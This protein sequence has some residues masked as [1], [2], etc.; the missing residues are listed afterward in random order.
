MKTTSLPTAKKYLNFLI[1][2]SK[3]ERGFTSFSKVLARHKIGASVGTVIKE[4]GLIKKQNGY[5]VWMSGTP[6]I[7]LAYKI[8]SENTYYIHGKHPKLKKITNPISEKQKVSTEEKSTRKTSS[9]AFERYDKL[10]NHLYDRQRS[11]RSLN[12]ILTKFKVG[13]PVGI[14]LKDNK[15]VEKKDGKYKWIGKRPSVEL[16]NKI[17]AEANDYSMGL[18]VK[19]KKGKKIAQL[20]LEK[21]ED[22]NFH[23]KVRP[24]SEGGN[25]IEKEHSLKNDFIWTLAGEQGKGKTKSTLNIAKEWAK[26]HGKDFSVYMPKGKTYYPDAK[27]KNIID[28]SS[29]KSKRQELQEQIEKIDSFLEVAQDFLK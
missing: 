29:L 24:Y 6:T 13:M 5:Y 22:K 9:S 17:I 2:L 4:M 11:Y 18:Y 28:I 23:K 26:K 7:E 12:K 8:I 27:E 1:Y 25:E 21:I 15:L 20:H 19:D 10:L 16:V 3:R 14:V